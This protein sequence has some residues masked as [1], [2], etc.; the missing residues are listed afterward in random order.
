MHVHVQALYSP[1]APSLKELMHAWDPSKEGH[2]G[3]SELR[4][5]VRMRSACMPS[6]CMPS[7]CMC[8]CTVCAPP[9]S[10]P[11]HLGKSELRVKVRMLVDKGG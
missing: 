11:M 2:L 3:K 9:C 4:V 7:A 10:G 8:M 6:A 5:K 1:Q